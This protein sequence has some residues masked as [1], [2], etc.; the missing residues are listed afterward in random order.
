M[1]INKQL[2]SLTKAE[3]EIMQYIWSLG[4]CLVSDIIKN[5]GS[6]EIPHST[7]SSVVRILEK[8]NYV[9]HKTYGKTHLYYA[10]VPKEEYANTHINKLM[11][12]YF[13][14][15]PSELVSFLVKNDK[16]DIRELN[17]LYKLLKK[18]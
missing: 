14:N 4:E 16:L 15:S 11:K 7:I 5:M 9:A 6:T 13:D 3:E 18:K 2:Q 8:K 10:I 12:N 17:E 1:K